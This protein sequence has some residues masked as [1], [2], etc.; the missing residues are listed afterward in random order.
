MKRRL[1]ST[2]A[3]AIALAA[4]VPDQSGLHA[5]D[6]AADRVDARQVRMPLVLRPEILMVK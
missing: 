2:A 5:A 3:M 1:A 6:I 4:A